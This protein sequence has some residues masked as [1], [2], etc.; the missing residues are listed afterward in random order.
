MY[1]LIV[2]Q[3]K[4]STSRLLQKKLSLKNDRKQT[5]ILK[6]IQSYDYYHYSRAN[7]DNSFYKYQV[8]LKLFY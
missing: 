2:L 3:K 4:S 5:V 1:Q 8:Q 6:R 7:K